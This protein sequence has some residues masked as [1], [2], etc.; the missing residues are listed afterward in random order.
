MKRERLAYRPA[1]K[2]NTHEPSGGRVK[3]FDEHMDNYDQ[4]VIF[5]KII[6]IFIHRLPHLP[7]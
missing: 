5:T 2:M 1:V 3:F 4:E 7:S 6:L